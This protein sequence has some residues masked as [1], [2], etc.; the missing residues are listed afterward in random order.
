MQGFTDTEKDQAVA[1]GAP[2]K[3]FTIALAEV[4]MYFDNHENGRP[5]VGDAVL[6]IKVG[7]G[8]EAEKVAGVD[9]IARWL[10]VG[11]D[12]RNGTHF[13]QR[14]WGVS[15]ESITVEAHYTPDPDVAFAALERLAAERAATA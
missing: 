2:G 4:S 7:G 3:G 8:T 1:T 10:G 11:R 13:A 9:A 12:F 15:G 5:L 6:N 14:R